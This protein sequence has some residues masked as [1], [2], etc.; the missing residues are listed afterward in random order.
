MSVRTRGSIVIAPLLV[1][2][3]ACASGGGDGGS[4]RDRNLITLEELEELQ[5]FTLLDAIRRLRPRWLQVS[6]AVS[7]RGNPQEFPRVVVDRVPRGELEALGQI[8]VSDVREVR[9]L[10]ASDATLK[11]GTGYPAGAI[12][13]TRR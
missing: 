13:V 2:L 6:R 4:R 1:L 8:S 9:F 11:Y 12:E 7:T 5:Q 3:A 10:S